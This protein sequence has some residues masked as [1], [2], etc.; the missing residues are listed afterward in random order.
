MNRAGAIRTAPRIPGA[1]LGVPPPQDRSRPHRI[2]RR[3]A[4]GG[5]LRL[6]DTKASASRATIPPRIPASTMPNRRRP[7]APSLDADRNTLHAMAA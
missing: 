7:P 5:H 3:K 4:P 6:T 1:G 2:A